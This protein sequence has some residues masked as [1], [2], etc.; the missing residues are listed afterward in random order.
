MRTGEAS[1]NGRADGRL[2]AAGSRRDTLD[3]LDGAALGHTRDAI[4]IAPHLLDDDRAGSQ[5]TEI[6]PG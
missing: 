1:S 2:S 4:E 6:S 3:G 5:K